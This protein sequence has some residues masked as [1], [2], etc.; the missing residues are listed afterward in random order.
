MSVT[1]F[2]RKSMSDKSDTFHAERRSILFK[3][4]FFLKKIGNSQVFRTEGCQGH[5]L[6][7]WKEFKR[8]SAQ[9]KKWDA[10]IHTLYTGW[11]PYCTQNSSQPRATAVESQLLGSSLALGIDSVSWKWFQV[12]F[13]EWLRL[14]SSYTGEKGDCEGMYC[15]RLGIIN[16]TPWSREWWEGRSRPAAQKVSVVVEKGKMVRSALVTESIMEKWVQ[17]KKKLRGFTMFFAIT[18]IP[19]P[20]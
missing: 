13:I 3:P 12:G 7:V 10:F 18:C 6:L 14:F 16:L 20:I 9:V 17:R 11:N 5:I 19:S 1:S 8:Q 15:T 2:E 4:R